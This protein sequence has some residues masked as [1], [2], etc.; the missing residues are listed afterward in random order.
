MPSKA[1]LVE[2][3]RALT[4]RQRDRT[5]A[6]AAQLWLLMDSWSDEAAE[7]L[8]SQL[9]PVALA[10]QRVVANATGAY[11]QSMIGAPV[12]LDLD[13]VTG[14]A[15]RSGTDPSE[16][17]MR[18]VVKARTAYSRTDL[19]DAGINAG[20][21]QLLATVEQD[22]QLA[23]THAARAAMQQGRVDAY[24]RATRSAACPLC[25]AASDRV[26]GTSELLPIHSHCRCVVVPGEKLPRGLRR[27]SNAQDPLDGRGLL[28]DD[29]GEIG[30]VLDYADRAKNAKRSSKPRFTADTITPAERLQMKKAQLAGYEKAFA[31]GGGNQWLSVRADQVRAEIADLEAAQAAA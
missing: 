16:V 3:Y 4:G 23:S 18:A 2:A 22:L 12:R 9:L 5:V 21:D 26:Y 11:L 27:A 1:D 13:E 20:L 28:I 30:P 6:T 14:A 24:R 8:L 29:S 19:V 17:Y 31:A 15:L 10:G 25:V 7:A